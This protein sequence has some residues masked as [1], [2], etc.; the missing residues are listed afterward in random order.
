[1]LNAECWVLKSHS[2]AEE[3]VER[4]HARRHFFEAAFTQCFH[5]G[6]PCRAFDLGERRL[7]LE[8]F[9]KAIV[10]DD[11]LEQTLAPPVAETIAARAASALINPERFALASADAVIAELRRVHRRAFVPARRTNASH[12]SL[13]HDER[14]AS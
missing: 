1:M 9:A 5:P 10:G 13:I 4:R 7:S 2:P 14:Q 11:E 12:E 3:L 6:D 8:L